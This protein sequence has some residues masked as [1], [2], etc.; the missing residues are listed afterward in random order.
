MPLLSTRGAASAKGF[1]LT[2]GGKGPY[3]IDFLVVAGGGGGGNFIGGSGGA[4]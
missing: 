1:G 2:S 3:N 4:G